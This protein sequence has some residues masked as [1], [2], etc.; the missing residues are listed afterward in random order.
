MQVQHTTAARNETEM[1]SAESTL[2][3][4]V[5]RLEELEAKR[6]QYEALS[7]KL[8]TL[9]QKLRHPGLIPVGPRLFLPG[10]LVCTNE[11]TVLLGASGDE[12]FFAERSAFQARGIVQRR[13][14]LIDER[15]RDLCVSQQDCDH[16]L[17]NEDREG[18]AEVSFLPEK[19]VEVRSDAFV[20][21][22]DDGT[23]REVRTGVDI[24][25]DAFVSK[26]E[27][28]A[29]REE[30]TS[31]ENI[32]ITRSSEENPKSKMKKHV[33]FST[34]L[35]TDVLPL[36]ARRSG[37]GG[38]KKKKSKKL[39]SPPPQTSR[40]EDT[41][42]VRSEFE[43]AIN[44]AQQ[45]V[46]E[47]GI[48]NITEV[49]EKSGEQPSRVE[50]PVGF[51]PDETVNFDQDSEEYLDMTVGGKFKGAAGTP[52]PDEFLQALLDAE[53]EEE[54]EEPR[55]GA[56]RRGEARKLEEKDF[57]SGFSRGFF[58]A[59][60]AKTS[61]RKQDRQ[62]PTSA[63]L[64][65]GSKGTHT[66]EQIPAK[67]QTVNESAIGE[68][69]VE[70]RAPRKGARRQRKTKTSNNLAKRGV[71]SPSVIPN[72]LTTCTND[73][74]VLGMEGDDVVN[75]PSVSKFRQMRNIQ[76]YSASID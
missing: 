60:A 15:V 24:Q 34:P 67:V 16:A 35:V 74:E 17:R 76:K 23:V 65:P 4:S 5:A 54:L 53:Q 3:G 44:S 7:R 21:D 64:I 9:P 2:G 57:G 39:G 43:D 71:P 41:R 63:D 59:P 75:E 6:E 52:S 10:E 14:A 13:L 55:R 47:D 26:G 29:V 46:L 31:T 50:F 33:S 38:G 48:V 22:G 36:P 49:F 37:R 61:S 32:D 66:V 62:Q 51:R 28:F 40:R 12:S 72:E 19:T 45:Q 56:E 42:S 73:M 20:R 69:V 30:V 11:L 27:T 70:R 58:G 8:F 68:R 1:S 18:A 25:D